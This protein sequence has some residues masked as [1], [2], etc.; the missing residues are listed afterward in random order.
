MPDTTSGGTTEELERRLAEA[1]Q[2]SLQYWLEAVTSSTAGSLTVK[3]LQETLSWRI[4]RPLRAVKLVTDKVR[5]T[6]VRRTAKMIRVRLA[7][8]RQARRR[9]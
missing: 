6:G 1:E 5:E 9:G 2:Q 3:A 8:I 7:Q 4:T